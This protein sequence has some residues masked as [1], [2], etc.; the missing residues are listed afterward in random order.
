M[1]LF[2]SENFSDF[3]NFDMIAAV[4]EKRLRLHHNLYDSRCKDILLEEN[5]HK[6]LLELN[7]PNKWKSGSHS[8]KYD[9]MT[10][11]P[12]IGVKS[13]QI[14]LEKNTL[15]YSG[16]RLGS[17][18]TLEDKIE[19]LEDNKPYYTFFMAETKKSK[20]YFFCVLQNDVIS[21]RLNWNQKNNIFEASCKNYKFTIRE[22]MSDQIW[23]DIDLGMF[24]YMKEIE[25]YG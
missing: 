7:I 17:Q 18:K 4:M 15:T 22:T 6:A 3:F 5:F 20:S 21:Y 2:S 16:S 25:V 1:S 14:N 23:S 8:V 12:D 13:G 24:A 10:N 11:G 9:I 19:F